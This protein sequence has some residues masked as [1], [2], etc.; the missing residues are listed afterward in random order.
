MPPATKKTGQSYKPS[1]N[2]TA[3]YVSGM[4]YT[5]YSEVKR[6]LA[7]EPI[8]VQLRHI[9]NLSWIDKR[10]VEI[11]VDINHAEKMR[12][13]I[14]KYSPFDVKA[15]F[16]P[17]SPE[18]FNWHDDA[19][20][21]ESKLKILQH[22]FVVR[23]A[24]SIASKRNAS[25]REY[26]VDWM[27][28]RGLGQQFGQQLQRDGIVLQLTTTTDKSQA[29]AMENLTVTPG[30]SISSIIED[31]TETLRMPNKVPCAKRKW[32]S[33]SYNSLDR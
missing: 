16:D 3:I 12:N 13:R 8:G 10:I 6:I 4:P 32:S 11:L 14:I 31:S 5:R 29:V 25:T 15:R 23:L 26:I 9:Q 1:V 30:G 19:V 7:A 2:T 24:G 17:L 27:R 21:P 18:C 28:N 20:L 22:T 33:S